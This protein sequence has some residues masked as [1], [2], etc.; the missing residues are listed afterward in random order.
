[1]LVSF[2]LYVGITTVLIFTLGMRY[3][4]S[5]VQII[6]FLLVFYAALLLSA[7]LE[8]FLILLNFEKIME[9][10]LGFGALPAQVFGFLGVFSAGIFLLFIDYFEKESFSVHNVLVYG[11]ALGISG[12]MLIITVIPDL[13]SELARQNIF[14]MIDALFLIY[15]SGMTIRSLNVIKKGAFHPQQRKE[16]FSLQLVIIFYYVITTIFI[17]ASYQL[18]D[19]LSAENIVIFRHVIPKW[20][21]MIGSVILVLNYARA[22]AIFLQFHRLEKLLVIN[23]AGLLLFSHDFYSLPEQSGEDE[24]ILLSGGITAITS[25]FAETVGATGIKEIRFQ[26]KLIMVSHHDGFGVFLVVERS[27]TFL[28]RAIETFGKA[29]QQAYRLNEEKSLHLI[30]DAT[31]FEDAVKIVKNTFGY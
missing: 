16:A 5:R 31:V 30:E 14:G 27:S 1:M 29:F 22:R 28:W 8:F 9:F 11:M 17:S 18:A 12:L 23:K 19:F 21:V 26:D 25:I 13:A 7:V 20:S 10:Y 6:K 24:N 15:V 4:D 2:V 3:R